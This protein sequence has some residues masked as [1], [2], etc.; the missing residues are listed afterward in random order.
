MADTYA[1]HESTS[2]ATD[3]HKLLKCGALLPHET[4]CAMP[5]HRTRCPLRHSTPHKARPTRTFGISYRTKKRPAVCRQHP[6]ATACSPRSVRTRPTT[7]ADRPM[8]PHR[9]H[10]AGLTSARIAR[11]IN[12]QIKNRPGPKRIPTGQPMRFMSLPQRRGIHGA[13]SDGSAAVSATPTRQNARRPPRA[14]PQHGTRPR[15]R[16]PAHRRPRP[17]GLKALTA[18]RCRRS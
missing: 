10:A 1:P 4:S 13:R 2:A 11:P 15:A 6:N 14:H 12:P 16:P 17:R 9:P 3:Y 7:I 5:M 8:V 18:R